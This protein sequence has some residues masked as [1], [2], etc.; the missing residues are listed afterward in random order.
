MY[1]Q[2]CNIEILQNVLFVFYKVH[3]YRQVIKLYVFKNNA[4][5]QNY[6]T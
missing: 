2:W 3:K 6:L 4:I 1:H 5:V